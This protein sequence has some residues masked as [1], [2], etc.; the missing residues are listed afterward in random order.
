MKLLQA[1]FGTCRD[2]LSYR[3]LLAFGVATWLLVAGHITPEHWLTVAVVFIGAE[4]GQRV[5]TGRPAAQ[6]A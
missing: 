2:R 6:E 3:R 1:L 5:L 4:F